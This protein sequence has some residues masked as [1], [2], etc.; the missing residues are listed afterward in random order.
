MSANRPK[1]NGKG[2]VGSIL[3][4]LGFGNSTTPT[5]APQS[6]TAQSGTAQAANNSTKAA[7]PPNS[8]APVGTPAA[9]GV[10]SEGGRRRR[11][12]KHKKRSRSR[13]H[14]KT[15]RGRK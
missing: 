12:M 13:K 9:T 15:H 2:V 10:V 1:N 3:N 7:Q 6:G 4:V 11:S 14:K 8:A 5:Q